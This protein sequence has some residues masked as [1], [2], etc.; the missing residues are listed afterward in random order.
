MENFLSCDKV[1]NMHH[2]R[3]EVLPTDPDVL[4]RA[5]GNLKYVKFDEKLNLPESKTLKIKILKE[6]RDNFVDKHQVVLTRSPSASTTR[7]SFKRC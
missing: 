4:L 2:I 5:F 6:V 1:I 3:P 7:A